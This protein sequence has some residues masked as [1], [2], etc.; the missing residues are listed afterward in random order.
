MPKLEAQ[1]DTRALFDIFQHHINTIMEFDCP[2]MEELE[3]EFESRFQLVR[4]LARL[5]LTAICDYED[6]LACSSQL[7]YIGHLRKRL[8]AEQ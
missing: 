5:G 4:K 3:K 8:L 2:D 7:E 1:T 6:Y